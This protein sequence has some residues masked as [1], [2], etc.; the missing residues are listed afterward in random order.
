MRPQLVNASPNLLVQYV[1][2]CEQLDQVLTLVKRHHQLCSWYFGLCDNHLTWTALL[3][4]CVL[5]LFVPFWVA[6]RE[7]CSALQSDI[8][9]AIASF[10]P[11]A[12]SLYEMDSES[13]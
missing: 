3:V 11:A 5:L 6:A 9:M 8:A 4:A 2:K 7:T 13:E 1:E 12:L 10:S